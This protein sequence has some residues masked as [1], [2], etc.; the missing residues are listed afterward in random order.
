MPNEKR[1]MLNEQKHNHTR[2]HNPY[3][4][5]NMKTDIDCLKNL[6]TDQLQQLRVFIEDLGYRKAATRAS[7]EFNQQIHKTA[8]QR[9]MWRAAPVE[10]LED[11]PENDESIH[12]ILKF[13]ADGQPEFTAGTIR[14]L[15]QLA[16]QLA[17]TCT[18]VDD[19]M[20][21]LTKIT[22]MLCRFRNTS[23]RERMA[24][25]Q[26]G[27]LKLRQQQFENANNHDT[28]ARI[29][30]LNQKIAEAF[31]SHPVLTAI[32][33][34]ESM[35]SAD[36]SSARAGVPP[37][38]HATAT[39]ETAPVPPKN[40]TPNRGIPVRKNARSASSQCRMK[41]AQCSM[42][43]ERQPTKCLTDESQNENTAPT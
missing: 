2:N 27:K 19:D 30:D 14:A 23:V 36:V 31:D 20:N 38:E 5:P 21:A 37:A 43:N 34:A 40:K 7:E 16:F 24:A 18:A 6:S 8:L 29:Q 35:G 26:E 41:K 33:N 3:E 10:F 42:L 4:S 39:T 28:D 25:V 32:H 1:S 15:E 22:T 17:F 11:T 12:Q 13:A 9:F